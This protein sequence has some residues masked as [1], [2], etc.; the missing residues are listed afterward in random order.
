[1]MTTRI[2]ETLTQNIVAG[3]VR[4]MRHTIDG[5]SF[6]LLMRFNMGESGFDYLDF[7]F[8]QTPNQEYKIVDWYALSRGQLASTSIGAVSSLMLKPSK[9]LFKRVLGL[10]DINHSVIDTFRVMME[11][12]RD[13]KFSS[14]YEKYLTL[15]AEVRQHYVILT[16][17][18]SLANFSQD[19]Q[20]YID[21]LD[22][23]AK[24][25]GD[26][27]EAAF[28]L[29]DHYFFAENWAGALRTIDAIEHSV[30]ID[31]MTSLLR[32]NIY[33]SQ[34]DAKNT[35]LHAKKA[36]TIEPDMVD[37]YFSLALG[38]V[39]NRQYVLAVEAYDILIN[40]HGYEFVKESFAE[41]D[42]YRDFIHSEPFKYWNI[43]TQ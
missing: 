9:N 32:A 43:Y 2:S 36:V 17:G 42:V 37:A 25:H 6:R 13:K 7:I 4:Y 21:L 31:G 5:D 29:I 40:Q 10:S 39:M 41:D 24:Y 20:A 26:K 28:L 12:F 19:D 30:G 11:L 16:F 34:E 22:Q 15:P 33:L 1:M 14:A 27:A 8:S 23:L 3:G 18:I 38:Y 35:I